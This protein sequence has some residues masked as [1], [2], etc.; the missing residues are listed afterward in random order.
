MQDLRFVA[1]RYRAFGG[2]DYPFAN[3]TL[4]RL[5]EGRLALRPLLILLTADAEHRF[6]DFRGKITVGKA[7]TGK[8]RRKIFYFLAR[9]VAVFVQKTAL[10]RGY[11]ADVIGAFHSA[12]YLQARNTGFAKLLDMRGKAHI[13]E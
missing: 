2:G 9:R 10:D 13:L 3:G 7:R 4:C 1:R 12:L 5:F 6:V 8:K 11:A